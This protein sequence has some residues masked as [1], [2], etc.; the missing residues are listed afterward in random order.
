MNALKVSKS[1][2][3]SL[4]VEI[5]LNLIYLNEF[6]FF[7]LLS[8]QIGWLEPLVDRIARDPTTVVCPVIDVIND[9]TFEYHYRGEAGA[10]NVG[11]F[12]WNLQF[13]WHVVPDREKKR[14]THPWDPVYVSKKNL[15]AK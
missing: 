4:L 11:G 3:S 2:F 13:N 10:V 15:R 5:K 14:R 6:Y 7:S 1:F 8:Q 12:D 9:K